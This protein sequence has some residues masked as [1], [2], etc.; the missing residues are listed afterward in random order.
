MDLKDKH[1]ELQNIEQ[2]EDKYEQIQ[3]IAKR[4]IKKTYY[5]IICFRAAQ[6]FRV[7]IWK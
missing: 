7:Q 2:A 1:D 3:N 4:R 6:N 5:D